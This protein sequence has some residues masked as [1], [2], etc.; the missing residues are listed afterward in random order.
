MIEMLPGQTNANALFYSPMTTN[1]NDLPTVEI[2]F[3]PGSNQ[4]PLPPSALSPANGEW[5]FRQ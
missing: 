2:I 4:K 3:T 5:A 1:V